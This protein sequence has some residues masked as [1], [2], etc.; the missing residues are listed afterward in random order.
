MA[1]QVIDAIEEDL[2]KGDVVVVRQVLQHLSNK[3][4]SKIVP[5]IP[6]FKTALITEHL[7]A[8][9]FTPNLDKQ[10]GPDHRP[11]FNSGVVLTDPPFNMKVVS[12]EIIC[13]VP[14]EGGLIR[15]IAYTF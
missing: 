11:S 1:F 14:S 3:H 10:T 6:A 15:T 5:K 9:R 12:E 4:I 2:P 7:P 13:E 8:G